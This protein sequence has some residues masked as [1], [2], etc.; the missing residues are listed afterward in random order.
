MNLGD[1]RAY[2]RSSVLRVVE[3]W[4]DLE[5]TRWLN[6]AQDIFARRTCCLVDDA[7]SFLS[8][9]TVA[10]QRDYTL[11][12]RVITVFAAVADGWDLRKLPATASLVV[13]SGR[14]SAWTQRGVHTLTLWP[15]PDAAYSL[16]L[17]ASRLP[18]APMEIESDE[19]E[20]PEQ[21]QL[22]LCDWAGY[23]AMRNTDV[24]VPEGVKDMMVTMRK[25][26]ERAVV[27]GRRETYF[28][29]RGA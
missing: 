15:T 16:A 23:R 20:I 11:D 25:D 13:R 8:I 4:S 6:D 5:L 10:A 12:D 27:E 9:A 22:A 18:L 2:T 1:L 19:P 24:L 21:Y 26:W 29:Q 17:L 7:A 3:Q 28:N 14:P